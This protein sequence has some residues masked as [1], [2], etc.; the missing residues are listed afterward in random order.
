MSSYLINRLKNGSS[1]FGLR[2]KNVVSFV[3]LHLNYMSQVFPRLVVFESHLE[4]IPL[5]LHRR[6]PLVLAFEPNRAQLD[7]RP[8]AVLPTLPGVAVFP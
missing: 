7:E 4:F 8:V 1:K 2:L 6:G 5:P 3:R